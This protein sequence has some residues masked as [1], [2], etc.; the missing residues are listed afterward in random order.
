MIK[1]IQE[2][3]CDYQS[4]NKDFFQLAV[5]STIGLTKNQ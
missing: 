1:S 5:D 2:V 4:I 3:F